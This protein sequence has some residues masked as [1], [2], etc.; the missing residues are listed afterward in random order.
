MIKITPQQI[1]DP[2]I[3]NVFINPKGLGCLLLAIF[4]SVAAGCAISPP[5]PAQLRA[6]EIALIR[7]TVADPV[8]TERLLSLLD[9]RD[10]LL[11]ANTAMLQQYRRELKSINADYDASREIIVE[12]FDYYNRERAQKQLRFIEL[13]SDMK[14]LTTAA[15]W[16]V[17][18]KF[19]LGNFNPRQLVYDRATAGI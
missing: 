5:D 7:A 17:I 16:K 11:E 13:I 19:Q 9:D 8:L 1:M 10:R 3:L 12:M 14:A 4:I 6:D 2:P 18:A 15:E